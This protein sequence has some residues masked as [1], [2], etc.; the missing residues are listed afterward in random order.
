M[1]TYLSPI[2]LKSFFYFY[3]YSYS[4][5]LPQYNSKKHSKLKIK[6]NPQ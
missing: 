1:A 2:S 4:C 3:Q 6:L 5:A